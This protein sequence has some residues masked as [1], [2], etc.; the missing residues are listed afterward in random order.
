MATSIT[1]IGKDP[2]TPAEL[3]AWFEAKEL[4]RFEITNV[5]DQAIARSVVSVRL[6][7]VSPRQQWEADVDVVLIKKFESGSVD[8]LETCPWTFF[9]YYDLGREPQNRDPLEGVPTSG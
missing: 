3:R 7:V 5:V 2:A 4:K 6:F 8:E 9:N 1:T